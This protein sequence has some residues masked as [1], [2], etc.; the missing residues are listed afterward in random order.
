MCSQ[1]DLYALQFSKIILIPF[2]MLI[3][4]MATPKP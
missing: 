4:L 1:D 3:Y 2:I